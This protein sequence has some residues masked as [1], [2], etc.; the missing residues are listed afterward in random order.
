M[1][2]LHSL[3]GLIL[4]H[5]P[6]FSCFSVNFHFL[7]QSSDQIKSHSFTDDCKASLQ[8]QEIQMLIYFPIQLR[9]DLYQN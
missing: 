7:L 9:T 2:C 5:A 1:K 4:T 3:F 8:H 6:L